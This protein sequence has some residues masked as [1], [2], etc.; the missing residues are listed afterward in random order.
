[1]KQRDCTPGRRGVERPLWMAERDLEL[2]KTLRSGRFASLYVC[3]QQEC[4]GTVQLLVKLVDCK[5]DPPAGL[6]FQQELRLLRSLSWHPCI[7]RLVDDWVKGSVLYSGV[8]Y[9]GDGSLNDSLRSLRKDGRLMRATAA[10]SISADLASA[11]AH[12]HEH[13]VAHRAVQPE[14]V[15]L[16]Q[17]CAKLGCFGSAVTLAEG[18]E[19]PP[20]TGVPAGYTPPEAIKP[21]LQGFPA[22]IWGWG[23]CVWAIITGRDAFEGLTYEDVQM[24]VINGQPGRK[25]DASSHH[26]LQAL[27]ERCLSPEISRRPVASALL[28]DP[29]LRDRAS[30]TAAAAAGAAG[31]ALTPKERRHEDPTFSGMLVLRSTSRATP[32]RPTSRLGVVDSPL[33]VERRLDL[34]FVAVGPSRSV[35]E[36]RRTRR[37]KSRASRRSPARTSVSDSEGK[38]RKEKRRTPR[39]S[40]VRS[41]CM[42]SESPSRRKRSRSPARTPVPEVDSKEPEVKEVECL[43]PPMVS[44]EGSRSGSYSSI[45]AESPQTRHLF[46]GRHRSA[47]PAPEGRQEGDGGHME[48]QRPVAP[49]PTAVRRRSEASYAVYKVSRRRGR[50]AAISAAAAAH[51]LLVSTCGEVCSS[52]VREVPPRALSRGSSLRRMVSEASSCSVPCP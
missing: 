7:T 24:A 29:L 5:A 18:R 25:G 14:H 11:L 16:T 47:I 26:E 19:A 46:D 1:M 2:K 17:R 42:E 10:V 37:R 34:D 31:A 23:S 30:V 28:V 45:A 38:G 35:L 44:T 39:R 32:A 20:A 33:S 43:S 4:D 51:C 9:C 49:P 12:L 40:P 50:A 41:D 22:D 3:E 6:A 21:G 8:E 27:A 52:P 15:L 48:A 36:C 13:R